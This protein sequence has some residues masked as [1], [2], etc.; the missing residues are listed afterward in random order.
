MRGPEDRLLVIR[1]EPARCRLRDE[2]AEILLE[3]PRGGLQFVACDP[4][5]DLGLGLN[6][7]LRKAER[8]ADG[9]LVKRSY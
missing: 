9:K 6:P 2:D 8:E 1:E 7:N 4:G 3:T 5:G